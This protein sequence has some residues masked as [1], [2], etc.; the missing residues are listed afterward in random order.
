MILNGSEVK[1]FAGISSNSLSSGAIEPF[2]ADAVLGAYLNSLSYEL[3]V[4]MQ[5]DLI[6]HSTVDKWAS[7][8]YQANDFALEDGIVYKAN[9]ETTKKPTVNSPD[10]IVAQK[11]TS[12][13]I[14]EL[15]LKLRRWLCL[16]AMQSALAFIIVDISDNGA[17]R[18]I[19][20]QYQP[21]SN[22]DT[23]MVAQAINGQL[24]QAW[25]IFVHWINNIATCDYSDYKLA[26]YSKQIETFRT[27][28]NYPKFA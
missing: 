8:T 17:S 14:E 24:N 3:Y 12:T 26:C 19:G 6:D 10:W 7:G 18:K 11:F 1:A 15:W 4:A 20:G 5:A 28:S 21:A 16:K 27:Q 9:K 13:C 25:T 2:I 22:R 23:E